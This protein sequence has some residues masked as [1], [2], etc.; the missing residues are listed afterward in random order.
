MNDNSV[1]L[2]S[3]RR[4]HRLKLISISV[5]SAILFSQ[6]QRCYHALTGIISLSL[7]GIHIICVVNNVVKLYIIVTV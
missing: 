4:S 1:L 5:A 6:R 3:R 7:R 2:P